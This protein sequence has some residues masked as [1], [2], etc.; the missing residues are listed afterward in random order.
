MGGILTTPEAI[1]RALY[2]AH[3]RGDINGMMEIFTDSVILHIAGSDPLVGDHAGR[4][5]VRALLEEFMPLVAGIQ[6]EVL[7]MVQQ[8]DDRVA[9]RLRFAVPVAGEALPTT[10]VHTH[11]FEGD[12]IAE[13]WLYSL[14]ED[15]TRRFWEDHNRSS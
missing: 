5:H 7:D 12:R 15:V 14:D 13:S 9:V 4:D 10:A 11:R 1:I 6:T 3:Q 2:D 8:D